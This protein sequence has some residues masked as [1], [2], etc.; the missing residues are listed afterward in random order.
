MAISDKVFKNG[1]SKIFVKTAFKKF[2]VISSAFWSILKY[3]VSFV[4]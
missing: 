3:L 2:E 4:L 1:P